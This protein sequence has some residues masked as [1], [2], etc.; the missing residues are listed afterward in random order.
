VVL[1]VDDLCAEGQMFF[2]VE[3]ARVAPAAMNVQ[4]IVG[5]EF[6][7]RVDYRLDLRA[8]R[9]EFGAAARPSSGAPRVEFTTFEGRP[10]VE[11]NLGW[12]VVDSGT[13]AVV[14]FRTHGDRP[15]RPVTT[16]TGTTNM[17]LV[18]TTLYIG[19]RRVWRGEAVAVPDATHSA[20]DGLMPVTLFK[21][22]YVSNSEGYVVFE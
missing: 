4:G 7:S 10:A 22:V 18:R 1:S 9:L 6:L 13:N 19:R 15:A 2:F 20:G 3:M 14:R 5:Q 16:L 21:S 11:T 17:G 8:G 12:L